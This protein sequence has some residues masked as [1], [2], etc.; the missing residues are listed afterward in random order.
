MGN[1]DKSVKK[2]RFDVIIVGGGLAG[3]AAAYRLARSGVKVL[4]I[5]RGSYAGAKN[6]TGGRLYT[7]SLEKL[8]PTFRTCAPLERKVT[9]EKISI[10]TKT[11]GTTVEYL[12][13]STAPEEESYI[14]LRAKFDQW[15]VE[16]AEKAGAMV[17]N[18][19][20]VTELIREGY[21]I[22]G[23]RCGEDEVYADV[24]IL[25]DGVNSLLAEKHKLRE[26]VK[27]EQSAVSCK[28]VYTLPKGALEERFGLGASDGA[29]WLCLGE[30]THGQLGGGF[31]YTNKDSVSVGL[32][33]GLGEI[34]EAD[35]SIEEMMEEFTN[36]PTIAPLLKDGKLEERSGHVVPEA[37]LAG[38]STLSGNGYMIVGD[39]AGF[40]INL[41]YTVRGM[42]FAISTGMMAADT[43]LEA[44]D[45]GDFSSAMLKRYDIQVKDSYVGKDL[46]L[47]RHFPEFLDNKRIFK[48][49][50]EMVNNIMHEVFAVNG[51][52]A[53]PLVP[54]LLKQ[55]KHVG[56]QNIIADALK[57]VRSL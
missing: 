54:R 13:D 41:G 25:A 16:M 40:C 33:V 4:L 44:R 19:I 55:I 46:H 18:H 39:A 53:T 27:A 5:E 21:E 15:L 8:I 10:L 29:A 30:M 20:Q 26:P 31:I 1:T 35:V 28:E 50:P 57:G 37:G 2:E 32:V 12:N 47:Y 42:D 34:G 43:Y 7:H 11:A 52:G 49:Y 23:V 38:L 36:H 45:V 14:V 3:G 22:I 48:D 6:M 17:I 56:L 9:K 51:D 24:T